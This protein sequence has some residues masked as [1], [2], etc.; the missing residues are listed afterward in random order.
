MKELSLT[1]EKRGER[2][3]ILRLLKQMEAMQSFASNEYE[4]KYLAAHRAE[5]R[6]R[7]DAIEEGAEEEAFATERGAA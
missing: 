7:L 1:P 4:A 3:F 6:K 2:Q 5:M